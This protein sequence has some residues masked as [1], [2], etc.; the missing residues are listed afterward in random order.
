MATRKD[1]EAVRVAQVRRLWQALYPPRERIFT[2]VLVFYGWLQEHRP[3][4]LPRVKGDPY[5]RLKVD[6]KGLIRDK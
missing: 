2:K 1:S 5:Q 6:L 4:L 3:E